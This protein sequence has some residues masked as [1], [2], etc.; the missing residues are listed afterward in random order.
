MPKDRLS[1]VLRASLALCLA[2]AACAGAARDVVPESH[3]IRETV[4]EGGAKAPPGETYVYVAK[5]PRGVV[6]LAEARGISHDT[7]IRAVDHLAE[8]LDAC[9]LRLARE[10]K[11]V[12]GS[13]RIVAQIGPDGVVR[14]LAVKTEPGGAVAAN[15]LTCVVTPL[16]LTTFP[17]TDGDAG[18]GMRGIAIETEWGFGQPAPDGG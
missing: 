16:R 10:H 18:A 17:A 11:L 1:N 15:L 7:A 12:L 6:A 13:G 5:R 4:P 3:D 8:E 2:A 14:G 9:A